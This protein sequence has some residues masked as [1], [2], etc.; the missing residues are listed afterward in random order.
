MESVLNKHY[1]YMNFALTSVELPKN[2]N[3]N[4]KKVWD[5][6]DKLQD[7]VQYPSTQLQIFLV[8]CT[9]DFISVGLCDSIFRYL[10]IAFH[11]RMSTS[12][13]GSW[14]RSKLTLYLT[15][16]HIIIACHRNDV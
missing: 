8:A 4:L 1:D 15:N 11:S 9:G 13:Y 14:Y 2:F 5:V 16:K 3:F 7:S 12:G 6:F 10:G